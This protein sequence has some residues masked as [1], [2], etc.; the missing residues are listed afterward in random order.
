[1][2]MLGSVFNYSIRVFSHKTTRKYTIQSQ[3]FP[4]TMEFDVKYS[5]LLRIRF[6]CNL[7]SSLPKRRPLGLTGAI[8]TPL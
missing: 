3:L 2:R 4:L 7:F 5:Y 1:M 8:L 6:D